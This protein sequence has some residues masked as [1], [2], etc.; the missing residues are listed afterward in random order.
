MN[1]VES[2]LYNQIKYEILCVKK[3]SLFKKI[4]KKRERYF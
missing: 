4:L 1:D 2:G 3:N